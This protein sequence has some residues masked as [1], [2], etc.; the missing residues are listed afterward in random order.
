MYIVADYET[1]VC[2]PLCAGDCC[3]AAPVASILPFAPSRAFCVVTERSCPL[4]G[5][6]GCPLSC[7][8]AGSTTHIIDTDRGLVVEHIERWKSEPGE[9]SVHVVHGL[10]F[11][12][13][14][15]WLAVHGFPGCIRPASKSTTGTTRVRPC[16][17]FPPFDFCCLVHSLSCVGLKHALLL[18]QQI[19]YV[20]RS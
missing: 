16:M 20:L 15:P 8:L 4:S 18:C 11:M 3:L 6:H 9:A 5:Q 14:Y 10:Q 19:L 17:Q 7:V 12:A 13:C 1:N 2:P